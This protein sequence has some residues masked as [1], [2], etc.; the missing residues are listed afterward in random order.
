MHWRVSGAGR[1]EKR[2]KIAEHH[3]LRLMRSAAFRL[4]PSSKQP[5]KVSRWT[6]PSL[7]DVH[8]LPPVINGTGGLSAEARAKADRAAR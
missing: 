4:E 3:R 6:K 5:L 1:R 2:A 8:A 7:L